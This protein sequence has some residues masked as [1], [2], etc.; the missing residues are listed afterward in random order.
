MLVPV[1]GGVAQLQKRNRTILEQEAAL[2]TVVIPSVYIFNVGPRVWRGVGGGKQ[3]VVPGLP[4][5]RALLRADRHSRAGAQRARS[6]GRRQQPRHRDRRGALGHAQG[7]QRIEARD[8]RRRRRHRQELHLARARSAHHERRMV[9]RVRLA[10]PQLPATDD[11][12]DIAESK[13]RDMMQMV[14]AQGAEKVQA[15]RE[16]RHGGPPA[17]QRSRRIPARE[18]AVGQSRSH[19]GFLPALRR[20][21]PQR[22]QHLQALPQPHRS[23]IGRS[24]LPQAAGRDGAR[25]MAET[26]E[27]SDPGSDSGDGAEAENEAAKPTARK[28]SRGRNN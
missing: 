11:E 18:A 9:R 22:R 10:E 25:A 2:S 12:I 5:G 19:H 24:L 28:K 6:G 20:R 17:L 23:G 26:P 1:Q 8:G 21:H 4:Q 3:W 27:W 7:G 14:Y 15:G 13:L 16:G